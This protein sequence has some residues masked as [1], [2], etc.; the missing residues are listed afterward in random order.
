MVPCQTHVMLKWQEHLNSSWAAEDTV[1]TATR[2]GATS[3]YSKLLHNKEVLG[4]VQPVQD[5][6]GPRLPDFQYESSAEE[7]REEYLSALL[8]SQRCLAHRVLA[9]TP[10]ALSLHHRLAVLQRVYYALHS[11]Y[12]DR[13]RTPP[14]P[15]PASSSS[16]GV[17][18]SRAKSGTDVLIE[19]GVR[20]GLSLLFAL[21]RQSWQHPP[22]VALCNEVLGTAS[23]VLAALPPLSLANE[24]KIPSV[25]LD[26]LAQVSDFL[27]KTAVSGSWADQAGRRLA[28]E[29][30][31]GLA[32]QRGSLRFL[33]EWVEVALATSASSS[34]SS[35]STSSSEPS[36]VGYELI[37]QILQQMRQYSGF[38]GDYVNTQVLNKDA[39]GLCSLS[40][41]ALCL[42]EEV[43]VCVCDVGST[44]PG[45]EGDAVKVYVWGSNSSHQL[46]E[47]TLEK[48]L[49]PKLAQGFSD[50]Q[51]IEAGQ[52]CTFS[53]SADGSVRACGKGSYGRLGLGDSN[54]QSVPKKLV[55]DPP[56]TMR[57]VSS[58]KGSDGHTLA[59]TAEGEVFSWGDGDYGKLGHG[60]SA[61]QK[62]PK[63]IQ[64]PLLGKVRRN[65]HCAFNLAF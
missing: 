14:P 50:A 34:S 41:V 9:R 38:R 2:S 47:G 60:N 61:T 11:K 45:S 20:T 12:H 18:G 33:L 52:Y 32:V 57:K 17:A 21:L 27:K 3:L 29:L 55:L 8:H 39:D 62:Y 23:S 31:L 64:G 7:E 15:Q 6:M 28:L 59:V 49:Q 25:G 22:D 16:S 65:S 54:N 26:C 63:I 30:L 1:Q 36:G 10:Y 24:N 44:S 42:F 19:M 43:G 5:L 58:S 35:S 4:L 40:H 37:S 51:M 56:R 53:V 13:F 48:I 46:A